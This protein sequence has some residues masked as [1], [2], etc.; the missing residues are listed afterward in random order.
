MI[1]RTSRIVA[2]LAAASLIAAACGDDDDDDDAASTDAPVATDAAVSTDAPTDTT[3]SAGTEAPGT[4]GAPSDTTAPSD[5]EVTE[6][7]EGDDEGG[8]EGWTVSTDDCVDPDAANEPIEGTLSIGSSMPLSGGPRPRRS[9][10][11]PPGCRHTSTTPTRTSW[12]PA[13]R[14]SCRSATTSTTRR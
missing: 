12:C 8:G 14:S 2:V 3:A 11:S 13:S 7:T 5:T 4:T 1:R 6:T 9:H 10:P